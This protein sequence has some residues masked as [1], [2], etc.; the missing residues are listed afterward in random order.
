MTGK[1]GIVT[2]SDKGKGIVRKSDLPNK[3][4]PGIAHT[5]TTHTTGPTPFPCSSTAKG[6]IYR[7]LLTQLVDPW[8]V[9]SLKEGQLLMVFQLNILPTVEKAY[10]YEL[11]NYSG[12]EHDIKVYYN[13]KKV[14]LL[15]GIGISLAHNPE[16]SLKHYL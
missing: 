16:F 1:E 15:Q 7:M 9:L 13:E 11:I 6:A 2:S 12:P 4:V 14:D 10:Y 5:V 3:D 8:S